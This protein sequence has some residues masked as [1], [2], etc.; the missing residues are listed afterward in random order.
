MASGGSAIQLKVATA[1]RFDLVLVVKDGFECLQ[2]AELGQSGECYVQFRQATAKDVEA[3]TQVLNKRTLYRDSEDI[4]HVIETT[5]YEDLMRAEV[6]LT[7]CG[8]DIALPDDP[9][10]LFE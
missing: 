2:K 8:T 1:K 3:R 6:A 10:H 7:L 5:S 9:I 4:V